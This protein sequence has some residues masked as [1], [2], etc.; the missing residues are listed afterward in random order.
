MNLM[1]R[2]IF[3]SALGRDKLIF[4]LAGAHACFLGSASHLFIENLPRKAI[5][6]DLIC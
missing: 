4:C 2:E 5:F 3:I 6:S 1:Y